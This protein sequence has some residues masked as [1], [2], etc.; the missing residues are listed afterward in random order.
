MRSVFAMI[1]LSLFLT[2]SLAGCA[3]STV[4]TDEYPEEINIQTAYKK[5][6]KGALLLDVRTPAEWEVL[7]APNSTLIPLD[8]LVERVDEL[9]QDAEIIVICRSGNR[10]LVARDILV[11]FGFKK[12]S[13]VAGGFNDWS[14][15]EYPI[16]Q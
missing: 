3:E 5:Y 7:H 1:T 8:E 11:D 12:T 4:A 13:S 9:P 10:S 16:V 2:M 15:A 14:A 6:K